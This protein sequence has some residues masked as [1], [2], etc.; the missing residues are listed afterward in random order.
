MVAV[1][2]C[3]TATTTL[4][5]AL[6]VVG[7]F[8]ELGLLVRGGG[9][10]RLVVI[11]SRC[12]ATS[13]GPETAQLRCAR[14]T[15]STRDA[16]RV[17]LSRRQ[18]ATMAGAPADAARVCL[19][20]PPP[21]STHATRMCRSPSDPGAGLRREHNCASCIETLQRHQTLSATI[22]IG[23][24]ISLGEYALVQPELS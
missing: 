15:A 16:S 14:L 10:V 12:L 11:I 4:L 2:H 13:D 22:R 19:A 24:K 8:G 1:L 17:N 3:C 5:L 6:S 18:S 23:A 9:L 20:A 21:A 7:D